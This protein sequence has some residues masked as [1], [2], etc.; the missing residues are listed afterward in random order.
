MYSIIPTERAETKLKEHND[1]SYI[2]V[3]YSGKHISLGFGYSIEEGDD[4]FEY[5]GLKF[6]VRGDGKRE[7]LDKTVIDYSDNPGEWMVYKQ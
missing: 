6:L 5:N 3:F 7:E 2:V 4:V 1:G